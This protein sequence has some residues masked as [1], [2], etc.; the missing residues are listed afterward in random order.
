MNP[1][2]YSFLPFFLDEP[3]YRVKD[4]PVPEAD[5]SEPD[6]VEIQIEAAPQP[7]EKEPAIPFIGDNRKNLLIILESEGSEIIHESEKEL[8]GKILTAIG[9]NFMDV[10]LADQN[11]AEAERLLRYFSPEQVLV[12]TSS[13]IYAGQHYQLFTEI[14]DV[15]IIESEPLSQLE[16][17]RNKK[18]KLWRLLKEVFLSE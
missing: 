17:D 18:G 2:D 6:N 7:V 16:A 1:K 15:L 14:P 5:V 4:A 3:I 8:L 12:F 10:A 11:S 9:Y 13:P